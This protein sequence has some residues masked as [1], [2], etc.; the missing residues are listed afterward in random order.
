[1]LG[2]HTVSDVWT[3]LMFSRWSDL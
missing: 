3:Q 2:I 1:M